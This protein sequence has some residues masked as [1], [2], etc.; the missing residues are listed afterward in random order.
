MPT[1]IRRLVSRRVLITRKPPSRQVAI[2][3]ALKIEKLTAGVAP[4]L[5]I[6]GADPGIKSVPLKK[7][8]G[9]LWG[10]G[11]TAGVGEAFEWFA[12]ARVKEGGKLKVTL[13]YPGYT[14]IPETFERYGGSAESGWVSF[15][16]GE[17]S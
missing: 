10:G 8:S 1:E 6:Y 16:P 5:D 7:V 4:S 17:P 9:K 11:I 3:F 13:S 15:T 14:S 2:D 12:Q